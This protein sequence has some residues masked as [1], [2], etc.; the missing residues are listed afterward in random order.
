M[1][2]FKKYYQ[3]SPRITVIIYVRERLNYLPDSSIYVR[4]RANYLPDSSIYVRESSNYLPN[5]SIY[6]RERA[7]YLPDSFIY[8]R[9]SPNYLPESPFSS[10]QTLTL[11]TCIPMLPKSYRQKCCLGGIK[12]S[13]NYLNRSI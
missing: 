6:V 8:V 11:I 9:E 13:F 7:N 12:R 1:K 10:I 5:S 4:E 2:G 3:L